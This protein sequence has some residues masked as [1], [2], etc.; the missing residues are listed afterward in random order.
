MDKLSTILSTIVAKIKTVNDKIVRRSASSGGTA[1]SMVN[2]GDMYTWNNKAS[3]STATTSANG[4]MSSADKTKMNAIGDVAG[5][6][7]GS[8]SIENKSVPGDST[9]TELGSFTLSK[10]VWVVKI[11]VRFNANATGNRTIYVSTTSGGDALSVWNANKVPASPT[12][13][14]HVPLITFLR[15]D[16]DSATYHITSQQNSGSAITAAVRWGAIRISN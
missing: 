6:I 7:N 14:T 5:A 1:L 11:Q 3:T 8:T 15:V 12:N 13:Y 2:T 9:I 10:G 16:G 4:L